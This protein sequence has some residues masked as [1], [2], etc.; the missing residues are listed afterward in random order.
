MSPASSAEAAARSPGT[1]GPGH[2][3]GGYAGSPPSERDLHSADRL[4][5]PGRV[6]RGR[7]GVEI[8]PCQN[9]LPFHAEVVLDD[10]GDVFV[11]EWHAVECPQFIDLTSDVRHE[12]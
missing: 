12:Q 5:R 9:C 10:D 1:D 3:C 8:W 4:C 6:Q 2:Y 7:R 11:R